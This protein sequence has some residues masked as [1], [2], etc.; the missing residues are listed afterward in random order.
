[1][2]FPEGEGGTAEAEDFEAPGLTFELTISPGPLPLVGEVE[3]LL[4]AGGGGKFELPDDA[5]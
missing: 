3:L 4:M 2:D 5:G 1:M